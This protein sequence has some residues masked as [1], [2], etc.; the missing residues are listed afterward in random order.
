MGPPHR[1]DLGAM[2]TE[3]RALRS[4]GLQKPAVLLIHV[5]VASL[6]EVEAAV[7]GEKLKLFAWAERG[8]FWRLLL[9]AI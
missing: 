3:Q 2:D 9:E 6:L 4:G 8:Y 7:S 5:V 1:L